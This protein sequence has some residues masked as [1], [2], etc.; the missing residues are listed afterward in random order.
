MK[1]INVQ[2]ILMV[3]T[4]CFGLSLVS[5]AVQA[6]T[7]YFVRHFEKVTSPD[8]LHPNDPPLTADGQRRA[9]NLAVLLAQQPIKSVFST[10]YK[11]TLQSALPTALEQGVTVTSYDP[12]QL[13]AFAQQLAL[14]GH[15]ALV[16]GHSNTTPFL[17]N[18]LSGQ[19]ISLKESDYG[20]IFLIRFDENA[21]VIDFKTGRVNRSQ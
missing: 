17:V 12:R 20:D 8:E 5:V 1:A 2:A 16:V 6:H 15:D 18:T 19:Q 9:L 11:R 3:V 14:L 10:Q 21:K 13:Q 7:V 4:L